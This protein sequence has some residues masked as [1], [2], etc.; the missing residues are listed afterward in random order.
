MTID[1][2]DTLDDG[3]ALDCIARVQST[4]P[5]LL[6]CNPVTD[7]VCGTRCLRMFYI[8]ISTIWYKMCNFH[9]RRTMVAAC[10]LKSEVGSQTH[11]FRNMK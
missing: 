1:V 7:S 6:I 9:G 2:L 8:L 10:D 11:Y 4:Y 5:I 3:C